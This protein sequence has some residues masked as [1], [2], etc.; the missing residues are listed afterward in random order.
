MFR[1][2]WIPADVHHNQLFWVVNTPSR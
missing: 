1:T 2:I